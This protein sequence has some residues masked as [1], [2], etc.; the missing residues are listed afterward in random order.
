MTKKKLLRPAPR[1]TEWIPLALVGIVLLAVGMM[2][3]RYGWMAS[4]DGQ[5]GAIFIYAFAA[6]WLLF[7]L[8]LTGSAMDT[9]T[10][11]FEIG[12]GSTMFAATI[13]EVRINYIEG[14]H[15]RRAR[16]VVVAQATWPGDGTIHDF[17]SDNLGTDVSGRYRPGQ[18][19]NIRADL[20]SGIY[21]MDLKSVSG[22]ERTQ[23][24]RADAAQG[25]VGPLEQQTVIVPRKAYALFG[26][27]VGIGALV[28]IFGGEFRM[29]GIIIFVFFGLILAL[30]RLSQKQAEQLAAKGVMFPATVSRI[31]HERYTGAGNVRDRDNWSVSATGT[32]PDGLSQVFYGLPALH[33]GSLAEGDTVWIVGD[34]TTRIY[35]LNLIH[36]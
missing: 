24:P 27:V 33:L 18:M 5:T 35:A 13:V 12:R 11:L 30:V 10:R 9:I 16:W 2:I 6:P 31:V 17:D 8:W 21:R 29:F 14:P 15:G 28:A 23:V 26:P 22:V 19:V 36:P 1:P 7:G 3:V 32:W 20:R 4:A 34:P 25:D